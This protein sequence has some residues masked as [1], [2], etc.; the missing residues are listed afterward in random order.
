MSDNPVG[1][2]LASFIPRPIVN[3]RVGTTELTKSFG[4]KSLDSFLAH[5]VHEFSRVLLDGVESKMK[6]YLS[7][8]SKPSLNLLLQ[9]TKAEGVIAKLFSGKM[10]SYI[11]CVH[12]DY[13]SSRIEEFDG[14][15]TS[16]LLFHVPNI[17]ARHPTQREGNEEF[18]RIIQGLCGRSNV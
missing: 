13:E 1:K 9:G 8:P 2:L 18:V 6:V 16:R 3:L 12:V 10:K 4:W 15:F 14:V 5:D 17:K 11:K 7:S